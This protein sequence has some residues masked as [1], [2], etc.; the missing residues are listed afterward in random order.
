VEYR[1]EV[2]WQADVPDGRVAD[3]LAQIAQLG[4]NQVRGAQVSDLYFVRGELTHADL[5]RL[6]QELLADPIVEAYHTQDLSSSPTG[7]TEGG[8]TGGHAHIVEVGFHP[9]VTD[10]VAENLLQRAHLLGIGT[11]EAA[12]TGKRY[13]FEGSLAEDDLRQI[14]KQVLCNKVIQTYALGTLPPSFV[15]RAEPSNLVE[16]VPIR[17]ADDETLAKMSVERVLFLSLDE[18]KAIQD[19]FSQLGRD[20]TDVELETLAQTWSEHC[21]H[22]AFKSKIDYA[23]QGGI[24]RVL[25]GGRTINPPYQETIDGGMFR[26]YLRAA[27]ERL[28]P[29]WVLSVFV[30]NAGVIEF[31]DEHEVSFKVETH[32]H[33]SALEPFGGANTGVGGVIRDVIGV[34]ARPIANT[35]VLC[36]GPLDMAREDMPGGILHPHRIARGVVDG[37]EDYGNKMGI[38]TVSGAMLY[39]PGYAANPLVYCGCVGLAKKGL[40][41]RDPQPGDLCV[42]LGGRTGRDGIHGATFSSAELTHETGQTVGSVVQIGDPITEKA[43]LEAVIIARDEGLYSAINDCGAGGFSSAAGEI[44]EEIGVEIEL[45]DVRLKYPGLRPWEIWLSEAQE[46]MVLAVPPASLSRLR[47]ICDELDVELTVIGHYTGDGRLRIKYGGK[48][49]ADMDMDFVHNGWPQPN[50]KAVWE[51]PDFPAPNL[52]SP[53]SDLTPV[54]LKMLA[55]P[56]VASKEPVI[57]RYDHE[58]QAATVVKPLVGVQADGPSDAAVLRPLETD[59]YRGLALGCGITPYYGQ[60]DPY[61][62]A[63]AVVDE[64]V[65]NVVAVGADPDRIAVLDNFC[66]GSP[67]LPDRMGGLVRAAQ[68]CHDAALA[69]GTPFISGKDSL[70]NEY[71]DPQGVK[72]PIPPT[73][74]ISSMAIVPDVRQAVTM[75]LK[76]PDNLVY[77]VGETRAEL[78]ASLYYRLHGGMGTS[79]PA[80]VPDAVETM[81]TLHG[82]IQG[83]LVRACHDLSEGGLAVAAAE[84]ACAGR[85]GLEIDLNDLPRTAEVAFDDAASADAVA[86]FS[87]SCARFLVEVAPENADAF[88]EALT[89]RP[90]ARIGQVTDGGALRVRGLAGDTVIERS[91]Q[92]LLRAWQGTEV[93]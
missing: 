67:S 81:R 55:D 87:E 39:D 17:Q 40:R 72:R 29:E 92:D 8:A 49:C 16:V 82:A 51:D 24:P 83:G 75:D 41:K 11:I 69:Y 50:H 89:G 23:C 37:I 70:N 74:L 68:G 71:V 46:R 5:E 44:G 54:L 63:W 20:P 32:N 53:V 91:I 34:S 64:A 56:D 78:G 52:Q 93:V 90:V 10:P 61:A 86:L 21:Q 88:E 76:T 2:N 33:P 36:F 84:M 58:V 9:G 26:T 57:R 85:M 62:M 38:P 45:S 77:V 30:D 3:L 66:W 35:D 43:M 13:V 22:K 59:G 18:M 4:L 6:A 31:D 73:L 80:P 79:V 27:T 65:R 15:P 25:P 42:T 19:Y 47:E 7:G 14:A 60:I 12:S 1:I 48:T 28:E